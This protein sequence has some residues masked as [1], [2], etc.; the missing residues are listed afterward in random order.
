MHGLRMPDG[1]SGK[2]AFGQPE[3]PRVPGWSSQ[4][5]PLLR[6]TQDRKLSSST[7]AMFLTNIARRVPV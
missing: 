2:S 1:S 5:A 4:Q 6:E 7:G 3:S